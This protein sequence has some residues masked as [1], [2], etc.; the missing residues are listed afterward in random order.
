MKNDIKLQNYLEKRKYT[1]SL[2]HP[3][4]MFGISCGIIPNANSNPAPRL[5]YQGGMGNSNFIIPDQ[6]NYDNKFTNAYNIDWNR[7]IN[8]IGYSQ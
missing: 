2:I 7:I 1:H 4:S 8:P 6:Y 5:T 3:D